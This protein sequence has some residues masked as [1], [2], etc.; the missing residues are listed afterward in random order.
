VVTWHL[1]D[2]KITVSRDNKDKEMDT[3]LYIEK[4]GDDLY[5]PLEFLVE[6]LE[7]QYMWIPETNTLNVF[8]LF[9]SKAYPSA[10]YYKDMEK[11]PVVKNQGSLGTCWAFAALSALESALLPGEAYEFSVD[12][13]TINNGFYGTQNDGGEY[14]M[15]L[16]YLAAW[17][18]PVYAADDPYGDGVSPDNLKAVKHVQE[19]RIIAAKDFETIKEMVFKYGAVQTSLYTSLKDAKDDSEFYNPV[20]SAYCYIGKDKPNHDVVIVGWDDNYSKDNFNTEIEADG[21]FI[22]MNSWGEAFGNDGIFYVSYYDTNIGIHNI[23]YTGVEDADNYDKI[24]QSDLCGWVGQ[25]GYMKDTAYFANVYTAGEDETLEAVSFYAIGKDTSYEVFYV[26]NFKDQTS[27]SN[28]RPVTKGK[29]ENAGYYTVEFDESIR[30]SADEKFAVVVKIKTPGA[31]RPIAVEYA[32]DKSTQSVDISDG[33]GYISL[34]GTV[35]ENTEK[36]QNCNVCLKAF[37]N[38]TK[39][40]NIK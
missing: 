14:T 9:S 30:L 1:D 27:F 24:Y 26:P 5:L 4:N 6:G 15:A 2:N 22:C 12:H 8:D 21:A 11:L 18:G 19:A 7:C 37:T 36:M 28:M 32:V 39:A 17:Q 31:E 20:T 10:L 13:M 3:R 40:G 29:L 35:W 34:Q 33:E 25:L 16:A 38:K 23:V